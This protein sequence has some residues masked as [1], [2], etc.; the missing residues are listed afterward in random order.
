MNQSSLYAHFPLVKLTQKRGRTEES[1]DLCKKTMKQDL[2]PEASTL[3]SLLTPI[4]S[5]PSLSSSASHVINSLSPQKSSSSI[6]DI[7]SSVPAKEKYA[8]LIDPLRGFPLPYIYKKLITFLDVLDKSLNYC[9]MMQKVSRVGFLSE[10]MTEKYKQPFCFD[11]L[12]QILSLFQAYQLEWPEKSLKEVVVLTYNQEELTPDT[13]LRRKEKLHRKLMSLTQKAHESFCVSQSL[14]APASAWH[15]DFDLNSVLPIPPASLNT[16]EKVKSIHN[17]EVIARNASIEAVFQEMEKPIQ[18][19][20]KEQEKVEVVQVDRKKYEKICKMCET[21]KTLFT[22]LKTPSIFFVNLCRKMIAS[23]FEENVEKD[24]LYIVQLFPQ[25]LSVI[26]T[27]SGKVIRSNRSS[28][29][30]LKAMTE[31]VQKAFGV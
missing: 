1:E 21:F 12:S 7:L 25:W 8:D 18:V 11:L 24:V 26:S 5:I 20:L 2:S 23:G 9:Q 13:M 27:N 22:S 15:P 4:S 3:T 6:D 19:S 16:E 17:S 30:T 29:L 10:F 31:E 14:D 28:G